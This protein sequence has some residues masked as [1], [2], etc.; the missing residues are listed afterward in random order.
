MGQADPSAYCRISSLSRSSHGHGKAVLL[1]NFGFPMCSIGNSNFIIHYLYHHTFYPRLVNFETETGGIRWGNIAIF[2]DRCAG[3]LDHLFERDTGGR[4]AFRAFSPRNSGHRKREMLTV[5]I[6]HS[7]VCNYVNPIRL[8][9]VTDFCRR[10]N[11]TTPQNVWLED[12]DQRSS[13][14]LRKD[15]RQIPVFSRRER[16]PRDALTH[17]FIANKIIGTGCSPP[18]TLTRKASSFRRRARYALCQSLS[19]RLTL[20]QHYRRSLRAVVATNSSSFAKPSFPCSGPPRCEEFCGF[21]SEFHVPFLIEARGV[22]EDFFFLRTPEEF[23]NPGRTQNFTFEVPQSTINRT[24]GVT[25]SRRLRR[26][27]LTIAPSCPTLSQL[28]CNSR[29]PDMGQR[30]IL[31]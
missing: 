6:V 14:R 29:R 25:P 2:D 3:Q 4:Y 22:A 11:T 18:S 30:V 20:S 28:P 5:G 12:V 8:C 1:Q 13:C 9:N 27:R 15:S 7:T 16:L 10:G 31:K 17:R 19:K 26:R 24:D 23:V 21:E